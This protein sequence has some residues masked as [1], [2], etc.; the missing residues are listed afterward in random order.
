MSTIRFR[1]IVI[2]LLCLDAEKPA[3]RVRGFVGAEAAAEIRNW[4][5]KQ[6]VDDAHAQGRDHISIP[7]GK[8]GKF[9]QRPLEL[10][11]TNLLGLAT[12]L[13]D[14]GSRFASCPPAQKRIARF[15]D[16]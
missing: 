14:G 11:F 4:L 15:F 16:Q 8:V 9:P 6:L 7:L 10:G 13:S 1:S 12:Q 2:C 3:R 5:M